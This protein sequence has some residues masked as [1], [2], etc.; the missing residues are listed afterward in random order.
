[1]K[2]PSCRRRLGPAGVAR[3]L[4]EHARYAQL[5]KCNTPKLWR[6]GQLPRRVMPSDAAMPMARPGRAE[7][8]TEALARW[9]DKQATA[10]TR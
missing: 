2:R 4:S 3:A 9:R 10:R 1:M 5:R 8:A 7:G 6:A